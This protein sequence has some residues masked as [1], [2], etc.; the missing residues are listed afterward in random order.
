MSHSTEPAPAL[1]HVLIVQPLDGLFHLRVGIEASGQC[2]LCQWFSVRFRVQSRNPEPT[3][4]LVND[5]T[6]RALEQMVCKRRLQESP[7]VRCG[8]GKFELC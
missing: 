5:P 2:D 8:F 6:E 7:T 3:C 4:Q 1:L